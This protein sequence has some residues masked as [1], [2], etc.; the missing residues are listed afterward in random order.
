MHYQSWKRPWKSRK[1]Q[2]PHFTETEPQSWQPKVRQWWS[3]GQKDLLTQNLVVFK[4]NHRDLNITRWKPPYSY[5]G[6][7][8]V[9]RPFMHLSNFISTTAPWSCFLFCCSDGSRPESEWLVPTKIS[10]LLTRKSSM[11]GRDSVPQCFH[12]ETYRRQSSST[13]ATA[14]RHRL[15]Y[16]AP[17][18]CCSPKPSVL[19]NVTFL[20]NGVFAVGQVKK[21]SLE[22][23]ENMS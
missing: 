8:E 3:Q 14:G 13:W 21:K 9:Q 11:V 7:H 4:L 18:K 6:I 15:N 2:I 23:D 1:A 10:L 20:G 17:Q 19:A 12:Y 16:A 22:W 5:V